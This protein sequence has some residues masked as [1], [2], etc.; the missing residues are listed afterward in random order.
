MLRIRTILLRRSLVD[1]LFEIIDLVNGEQRVL[2]AVAR[3][4]E[5]DVGGIIG[6]R[7][8]DRADQVAAGCGVIQVQRDF[9]ILHVIALE[10]AGRSD[11]R[12]LQR[13]HRDVGDVEADI[14]AVLFD[15]DRREGSAIDGR[16]SCAIDRD[17]AE[18]QL[19]GHDRSV[20]HNIAG[21]VLQEF[22]AIRN[23][24]LNEDIDA[25][26]GIVEVQLAA[27]AN[28][29][30]VERAPTS[31]FSILRQGSIKRRLRGGQRDH[32]VTAHGIKVLIEDLELGACQ[33]LGEIILVDLLQ[34][35]IGRARVG[36]LKAQDLRVRLIPGRD[37]RDDH[38]PVHNTVRVAEVHARTDQCSQ[39]RILLRKE[40]GKVS[41]GIVVGRSG[42]RERI[43]AGR[44]IRPGDD[45]VSIGLFLAAAELELEACAK[46]DAVHVGLLETEIDLLGV[47]HVD[48]HRD[49]ADREGAV[50]V[51]G[52]GIGVLIGG[53][54][55]TNAGFLDPILALRQAV[56]KRSIAIQV[57]GEGVGRSAPVVLARIPGFP[58]LGH[59]IIT[60]ERHGHAVQTNSAIIAGGDLLA[61]LVERGALAGRNGNITDLVHADRGVH[62]ESVHN[63]E[64]VMVFDDQRAVGVSVGGVVVR[65]PCMILRE[66]KLVSAVGFGQEEIAEE[67][68][69]VTGSTRI[70]VAEDHIGLKR[71]HG[72]A[73]ALG[74]AGL[75]HRDGN[76]ID[77][78]R[79]VSDLDI[80]RSDIIRDVIVV[81]IAALD[82]ILAHPDLIVG[83]IAGSFI[84]IE[85]ELVD[86]GLCIGERLRGI[87]TLRSGQLADHS[88][89]RETHFKGG[90]LQRFVDHVAII[91]RLIRP[92]GQTQR[93]K[94]D[95]AGAGAFIPAVQH[96]T[97][98][99]MV[100]LI[101]ISIYIGHT[102]QRNRLSELIA[103][104]EGVLEVRVDD[105]GV[106]A[107]AVLNQHVD[108]SLV[109]ALDDIAVGVRQTFINDR[110]ELSGKDLVIL[111]QERTGGICSEIIPGAGAERNAA[112]SDFLVRQHMAIEGEDAV[113]QRMLTIRIINDGPVASSIGSI[114]VI[115]QVVFAILIIQILGDMEL[116]PVAGVHQ[117]IQLVLILGV[118]DV[119]GVESDRVV[120]TQIGERIT[121]RRRLLE[122]ALI[123]QVDRAVG[124][125][126]HQRVLVLLRTVGIGARQLIKADV[127]ALCRFARYG[128]VVAVKHGLPGRLTLK[129][130]VQADGDAVHGVT[131][132]AAVGAHVAVL[133]ELGGGDLDVARVVDGQL[134]T[135]GIRR[136]LVAAGENRSLAV[137]DLIVGLGQVAVCAALPGGGVTLGDGIGDLFPVAVENRQTG[138]RGN[139][140]AVRLYLFG[141]RSVVTGDDHV[142]A[143]RSLVHAVDRLLNLQRLAV[144]N[145]VEGKGVGGNFF[146]DLDRSEGQSGAGIIEEIA[147][148]LTAILGEQF[149]ILFTG[150]R[151]VGIDVI[152]GSLRLGDV[153]GAYRKGRDR[154]LAATG[155]RDHFRVRC[156]RIGLIRIPVLV[157]HR[158]FSAVQV[159]RT[160]HGLFLEPDLR[161]GLVRHRV[162]LELGAGIRRRRLRAAGQIDHAGRVLIC[163][164][165]RSS[166]RS[167]R[168]KCVTVR[169]RLFVVVRL[170]LFQEDHRA[171]VASRHLNIF[172]FGPGLGIVCDFVSR[173]GRVRI[174]RDFAGQVVPVG[175][176]VF[177]D[178]MDGDR[179][180]IVSEQA[181]VG[182]L[183]GSG[184]RVK[185]D[186][187][188]V[189]AADLHE[190]AVLVVHKRQRVVFNGSFF[191]IIGIET[192][193]AVIRGQLRPVDIV[194]ADLFCFNFL[195]IRFGRRLA[196]AAVDGQ[197]GLQVAVVDQ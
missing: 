71:E 39:I 46:R 116:H 77:F 94:Y 88:T 85:D 155:N 61:A 45:T 11:L 129:P 28:F 86:A 115:R 48:D 36:D 63:A 127:A 24:G 166:V 12:R 109:D 120:R 138:E 158:E 119:S 153:V 3:I 16:R 93:G 167:E 196:H 92:L 125:K 5:I 25:G 97:V 108:I 74:G 34:A 62:R 67:T 56:G 124:I 89:V 69:G 182:Q 192:P 75:T 20:D 95:V 91:I 132:G 194:L 136:H 134:L 14:C 41:G 140:I 122:A 154:A 141:R 47:G 101:S 111:I 171:G 139:T 191:Y 82:F 59:S 21:I 126:L 128:L 99:H 26:I 27:G 6:I 83:G 151:G 72:E 172:E 152:I 2:G 52:A 183:P 148:A 184:R 121:G 42:L 73:V 133:A 32:E 180:Q 149:V 142:E 177:L 145:V 37:C 65:L 112:R 143:G 18:R 70:L 60:L 1:D 156:I 76:Q 13:G 40:L 159:L 23:R 157:I 30:L 176:R 9:P 58:L 10:Q 146:L 110:Q 31:R 164:R 8:G 51:I 118:D 90:V 186:L 185:D 175:K 78:A 162:G 197:R 174:D 150:R 178:H 189:L 22:I 54:G 80:L 38:V 179:L 130:S 64:R 53:V 181:L 17:A 107:D 79:L 106:G 160:H 49:L 103:L 100:E 102:G 84:I 161:V 81:R 195:K 66:I 43:L 114:R 7:D 117:I 68:E 173:A 44:E 137:L 29:A 35:D 131:E 163:D 168:D 55:R 104:P 57:G 147:L 4:L 113:I 190:C 187:D 188:I 144:Q 33:A 98:V 170:S 165:A 19:A 87:D 193:L 96:F 50:T 123:R 105:C 169:I 15:P 135:A